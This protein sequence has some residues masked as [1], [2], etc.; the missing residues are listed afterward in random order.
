MAALFASTALAPAAR[1]AQAQTGSHTGTQPTAESSARPGASPN[2]RMLSAGTTGSSAVS[3]DIVSSLGAGDRPAGVDAD[4]WRRATTVYA[5]G[6][7]APIWSSAG[8]IGPRAEQLVT[9]L[10]RAG[11]NG[12]PV[13]RYPISAIRAAVDSLA[14]RNAADRQVDSP[15]MVQLLAR[16]DVLLTA[17]LARYASDMLTGIVDPHSI[18]SGWHIDPSTTDVDSA[19]AHVLGAA[20]FGRALASLQPEADGYVTLRQELARY[21]GIA[22]DGG[23]QLI[24]DGPTIHPGDSS[25]RVP[26]IAARLIAE[27]FATPGVTGAAPADSTRY[28]PDLAAAIAGFQQMHGL[29]QDSVVGPRTLA[30]L[31]VTATERARQI[32]ANMERY[33]WLPHDLGDRYVVVNIPAFRLDAF[34]Q[35]ARQLSMRVVVGSEMADRHT[36]IF[37]DSMSYV[38]FGPYWKVP[39]SIARREII[40]KARRDRSYLTR[41]HFEVVRGWGDNARVVNPYHLSNAAL[42]SGRYHFRQKPGPDNALGR[43]K[44]I[45]PND[46][47]VYLHDTPATSLFERTAR[48]YSH[49]CVRVAEPAQLAQFVLSRQPEWT[50]DRIRE[51][52]TDGQRVKVNLERKLPVYILYLTAFDSSGRVAFRDDLYG[53][54][55]PLVAALDAARGE[56][57]STSARDSRATDPASSSP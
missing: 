40:P 50:P 31:N 30:A 33:R 10:T 23:W 25:A 37:S 56:S 34:D 17:T 51:T 32:A 57:P 7:Y 45:F 46:F 22:R 20:E 41:N 18:E 5:A 6:N 14:V 38:Q 27:G 1:A 21:R 24:P 19:V 39:E 16:T 48:A 26:S 42:S 2:A 55:A 8:R 15:R 4:A 9:A 29:T 54:D 11:D 52:L 13:N 44:F 12:I 3:T 35:G 43:V 47:N 53:L 36:P 28:T 49:G